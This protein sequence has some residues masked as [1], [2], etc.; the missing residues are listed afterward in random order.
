MYA[1]DFPFIDYGLDLKV[2]AEM[3]KGIKLVKVRRSDA[4]ANP[5]ESVKKRIEEAL[6]KMKPKRQ[7]YIPEEFIGKGGHGYILK[8]W[9]I[10]RGYGSPKVSKAF[11]DVV[12]LTGTKSQYKLNPYL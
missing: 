2:M 9:V 11:K 8:N 12:R 6:A 1:T 7:D 4:D 3:E 5:P 10:H